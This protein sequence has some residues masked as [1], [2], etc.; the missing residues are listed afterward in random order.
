MTV[1]IADQIKEIERELVLRE[2]AFPQFVARGNKTQAEA[3]QQMD[4][5]RAALATLKWVEKH[6]D[7]L[8][9]LAPELHQDKEKL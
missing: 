4:R 8:R 9:Q 7:R 2:R 3:D 1:P 6:Q 5:M